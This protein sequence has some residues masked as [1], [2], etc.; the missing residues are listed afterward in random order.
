MMS[1]NFVFLFSFLLVDGGWGDW[2]VW[3]SCNTLTGKKTRSRVCN[4]P[5]PKN[6]GKACPRPSSEETT[7]GCEG[8]IMC[9]N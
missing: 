1:Y 8:I 2:T 6:G 5:T 9:Y 3:G 7:E 4:K